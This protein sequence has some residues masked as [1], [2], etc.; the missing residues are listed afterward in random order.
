[1]KTLTEQNVEPIEADSQAAR[2]Y[3]T[4]RL[5]GGLFGID[6]LAVKEI[7]VMPPMTPIPHAPAA[8]RGC[9]NLRGQIV[10]V[11]D[12][13]AL[14]RIGETAI[15]S[16]TRLIVFRAHLGDPFG[17]L[18]DRIGDIVELCDNEIEKRISAAISRENTGDSPQD[19]LIAGIGKLDG[20]LLTILDG[21]KLLP[22]VEA[23]IE[24]Y[25]KKAY[26]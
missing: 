6:A 1:M 9:V 5:E 19:E 25:V 24:Q 8:V 7:A 22:H 20:E 12:A 26:H 17:I 3:C 11:L 18:A 10:L 15:D 14:L 16:L 4:F 23:V 21:G 13:N 2:T